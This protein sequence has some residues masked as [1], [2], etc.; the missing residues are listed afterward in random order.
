MNE[1]ID[2]TK[3]LKDCPAG[4]PLYSTKLGDVK[5]IKVIINDN[6]IELYIPYRVNGIWKMYYKLYNINDFY[7]SLE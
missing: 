4:T 1:N 5:L 2:L 6:T 3:I 7:N